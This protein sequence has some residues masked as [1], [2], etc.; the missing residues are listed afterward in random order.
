[1]TNDMTWFATVLE[2]VAAAHFL[3]LQRGTIYLYDSGKIKAEAYTRK[4]NVAKDAPDIYP[5]R[6]WYEAAVKQP[7]EVAEGVEGVVAVA[8]EV[9]G[10]GRLRETTD[11]LHR[12][13]GKRAFTVF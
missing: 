4:W 5:N 3:Q 9:F 8:K 11:L 7:G 6:A 12:G 1:M 10:G 13:Q 2:Y